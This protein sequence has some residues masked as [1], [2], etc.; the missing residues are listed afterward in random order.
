MQG[1]QGVLIVRCVGRVEQDA[2]DAP[3]GQKDRRL[4]LMLSDVSE[5][6]RSE[7]ALRESQR[8]LEDILEASLS[9][10]WDWNFAENTGYLSPG[11]KRMFGYAEHEMENTPEAWQRLVFP[12]DL[13]GV[14]ECLDRH[15]A[16]RAG[17]P[18]STRCAF[19]TGM[20]T[21]SG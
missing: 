11:L 17:S 21:R 7:N 15:V 9:G 13:P 2:G 16:T 14:L 12:E 6:V 5:Q 20:E 18:T 4:L 10:Y 1:A 8:V 19:N 3:G